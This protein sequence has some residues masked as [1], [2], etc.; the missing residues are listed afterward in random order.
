MQK[1][2]EESKK[3]SRKKAT[4]RGWR[5]CIRDNMKADKINSYFVLNLAADWYT[6]A[7]IK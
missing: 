4:Q 7:I 5:S 1:K 3:E 6:V 2:N